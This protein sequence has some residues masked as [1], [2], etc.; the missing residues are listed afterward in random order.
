MRLSSVSSSSA[1][2]AGNHKRSAA[3]LEGWY[4]LRLAPD[5]VCPE[6]GV[7]LLLICAVR[8]PELD[9]ELALLVAVAVGLAAAKLPLIHLGDGG[10]KGKPV[11]LL[12]ESKLRI[13]LRQ[14]NAPDT[15]T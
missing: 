14:R 15:D 7:V 5:S 11:L 12:L 9:Q 4:L 6:H 8:R 3:P 1:I 10:E 13:A 2:V